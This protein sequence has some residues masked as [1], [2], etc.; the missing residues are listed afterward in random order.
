MSQLQG[1]VV[2]LTGGGSG[3]G[4]SAAGL[5]VQAG[6]KVV[7]AG[8]DPAKLDATLAEIN[9][10]NHTLAVPTDV[11]DPMQCQKLI[12]AATSHFGPVN[13][14]INNAGTNIK[15]RSFRDITVEAWDKMIRANL[16]GAFY[17]TKAVL[18]QMLE[19]KN[20]LIVNVV[21]VA[22][23]RANP[24]G[25]VAYV[26]A[27]F[28]MGAMGLI[29]SNEEK[30]SGLR[31][32]NIYPGEIDTPILSERP[33]AITEAH[34]ATILQ[35]GD[36]AEAILFVCSLPARVSIPELVIKPSTQMYW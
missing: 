15:Q 16:D 20:G 5:L 31:V 26:A 10:P 12:E 21:S 34:R 17:C 18:P 22:G 8:R 30:D 25:G 2:V 24:L 3:V 1:Q 7:I 11:T 14:L 27:K 4:R 35:P 6:A 23:K 32:S 13:I 28:G 29:L 36:V 19:Q 9:S 33:V